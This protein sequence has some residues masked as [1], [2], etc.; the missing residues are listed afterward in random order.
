MVDGGS[1]IRLKSQKMLKL[2]AV[3]AA[4]VTVAVS[5]KVFQHFPDL[6]SFLTLLSRELKTYKPEQ[7]SLLFLPNNIQKT[8]W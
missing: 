8:M 6:S 5:E 4:V 2:S 3:A 7:S 1:P